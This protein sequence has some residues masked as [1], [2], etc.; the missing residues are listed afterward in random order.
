MAIVPRPLGRRKMADSED[1]S[2][3]VGA[4]VVVKEKGLEGIVR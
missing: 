4:R 1:R 3:K 2:L